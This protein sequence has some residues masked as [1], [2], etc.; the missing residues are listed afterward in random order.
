MTKHTEEA[1]F[2]S[3]WLKLNKH[4]KRANQE[5]A[6]RAEAQFCRD[7]GMTHKDAASA[8]KRALK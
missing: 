1:K 6:T 7:G 3:Y 2:L 5:P 8:I 4:L